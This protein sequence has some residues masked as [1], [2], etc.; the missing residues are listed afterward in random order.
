MIHALFSAGGVDG[1]NESG[2]DDLRSLPDQPV[3]TE[4]MSMSELHR[5]LDEARELLPAAVTLRRRIHKEPELGLGAREP[6]AAK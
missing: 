5:F 1:R 4:R 3:T 6:A 2:H